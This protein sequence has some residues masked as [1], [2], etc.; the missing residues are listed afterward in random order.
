MELLKVVVGYAAALEFQSLFNLAEI[1]VQLI[2]G[3]AN[4][5]AWTWITT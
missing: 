1:A 3:N 2:F 4:C 5:S